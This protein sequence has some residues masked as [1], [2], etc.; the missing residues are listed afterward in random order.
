MS[1]LT[2]QDINSIARKLFKATKLA[3]ETTMMLEEITNE[4]SRESFNAEDMMKIALK[5]KSLRD[6]VGIEYLFFNVH[7]SYFSNMDDLMHRID[8]LLDEDI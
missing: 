5:Y 8:E 4:F 6:K 2:K 3:S 7:D 1:D